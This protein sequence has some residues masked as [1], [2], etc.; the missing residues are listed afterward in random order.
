MFYKILIPNMKKL[1]TLIILLTS[2]LFSAN[3][4]KIKGII[5]TKKDTQH[6]NFIIPFT[7]VNYTTLQ[8][9]VKYIDSL[10]IKHKLTP[11]EAKEIRFEYNGQLV[12]ML[13][14]FD[15]LSY[16]GRSTNIFLHLQIDGQ[17]K[18]FNYYV[19]SGGTTYG[20]GASGG[21]PMMTAGYTYSKYILQK[22]NGDLVRYGTMNFKNNMP[23][24]LKKCPDLVKMI[25]DKLYQRGD[26]ERIINYYN[27]SCGS[28]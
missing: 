16:S 6:V 9:G 20:G 13:S 7:G 3:A 26:I 25:Q 27:T 4:S 5:I 14:R 15:N 2:I 1:F 19:Q 17:I 23:V 24:F 12:R 8:K 22:E 28:N 11:D 21:M 18:V 10:G